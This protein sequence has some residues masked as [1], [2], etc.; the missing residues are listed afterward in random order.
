MK[1]R[2]KTIIAWIATIIGSIMV[3]VGVFGMVSAIIDSIN[4]QAF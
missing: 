1:E 4:Q 3:A 2:T